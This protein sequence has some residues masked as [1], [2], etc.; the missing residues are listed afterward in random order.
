MQL[1]LS[2]DRLNAAGVSHAGFERQPHSALVPP[3]VRTPGGRRRYCLLLRARCPNSTDQFRPSGQ[4]EPLAATPPQ[5]HRARL[6]STALL[7]GEAVRTHSF[8]LTAGLPGTLSQ[9]PVIAVAGPE[10]CPGHRATLLGRA[11]TPLPSS[12]QK[13]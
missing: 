3:L 13:W 1:R 2:Q 10:A 7:R 4:G 11:V 12:A 5:R 8:D 9:H 6:L